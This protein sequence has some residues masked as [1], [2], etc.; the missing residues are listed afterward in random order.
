MKTI[1]MFMLLL[2]C[3]S[4]VV[5]SCKKDEEEAAVPMNKAYITGFAYADL[6][7]TEPGD[8]FVPAGTKLFLIL[9]TEELFLQPDPNT[10]Y[11]YK[12]YETTVG[13]DGKYSF[14]FDV[15][16]IPIMQVAIYGDEFFYDR[17]ISPSMTEM[18]V[19]RLNTINIGPI[20]PKKNHI[21]DIK[22][23]PV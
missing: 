19:F 8:E 22:F 23:Q 10:V 18:T 12:Y 11:P 7:M 9:N 13:S 14:S 4:V 1:K 3:S 21:F 16:N 15:G 5:S 2:L 6:D 20:F 17:Q